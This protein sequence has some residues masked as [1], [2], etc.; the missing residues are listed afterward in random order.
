MQNCNIGP[1]AMMVDSPLTHDKFK[2]YI[3]NVGDWENNPRG[4]RSRQLLHA[5]SQ[6]TKEDAFAYA[7]DVYDLKAALWQKA[8]RDALAGE[9]K[10]RSE[11]P[12]FAQAVKA[13]L[14]WDGQWTVDAT[15]TVLIRQWRE[16]AA[17][18]PEL[19]PMA[20]NKPLDAAGQKILLDALERAIQEITSRHGRWDIPWGDVYVIGRG[21]KFFPMPGA[22]F[23]NRRDDYNYTET[24]LS[25]S[26]KPDPENPSRQVAFKGS[27]AM[28]LMF[29]HPDGIESYSAC[30]WGQ[31]AEPASPHYMDQGEKLFSKRQLKPTFWKKDDLLKNLESEKT[32]EV[33]VLSDE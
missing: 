23:G 11:N 18:K 20:D 6:V 28:I 17:G 31:S 24:L 12:T 22:D 16:F 30:A 19:T 9:G 8:L 33:K 21:G 13:I 2:K 1:A 10:Q 4:D 26:Y 27:M 29:V 14:A 3:Y 25:I 32:L 5:D 7:M 15:P